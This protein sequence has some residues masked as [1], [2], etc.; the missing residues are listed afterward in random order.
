MKICCLR[1]RYPPELWVHCA[2][3]SSFCFHFCSCF[4]FQRLKDRGWTF[5]APVVR[6]LL[7]KPGCGS[8]AGRMPGLGRDPAGER[9]KGY[10][11]PRTREEREG[12]HLDAAMTAAYTQT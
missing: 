8:E 7:E 4:H 5:P 1:G 3:W 11:S 12:R 2:I 6:Y 10:K 9:R